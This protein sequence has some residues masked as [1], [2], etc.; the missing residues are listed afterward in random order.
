MFLIKQLGIA[1]GIMI[2]L[3]IAIHFLNKRTEKFEL[4]NSSPYGTLDYI[5]HPNALDSSIPI[6]LN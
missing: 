2:V 3:A 5:P 4:G 6:S 1:I